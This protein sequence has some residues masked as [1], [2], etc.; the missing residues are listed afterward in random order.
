MNRFDNC[1]MRGIANEGGYKISL[2][3][4][5]SLLLG[6]L[7]LCASVT[8]GCTPGEEIGPAN[9][10]TE[11]V[12]SSNSDEENKVL[13]SSDEM[14]EEPEGVLE[15]EIAEEVTDPEAILRADIKVKGIYVT[16]PTA[17]SERLEELIELVKTTELNTMVIDIKSDEGIVTYKMDCDEAKDIGACVGYVK[18]M[19]ATIQRL[20][21]EG[22]YVI[23]RIACFKDPILAAGKPEYALCKADGTPVTDSKGIA[24]VNPYNEGVWNYVCTLAEKASEIGF[25]EIQFDYVRFPIGN[26]ANSADYGVD[27]NEYP[28]Q[29]CLTKFFEYVKLRLHGKGIIFGADLF[30]TVIG[31]DVDMKSTGQDYSSIC[32][33]SDSV[34]PMIYPS[35]YANGSF[36]VPV[37]D[38]NPYATVK[39]AM[40]KSAVVLSKN[41]DE[42]GNPLETG[43]IRPWLQCFTATWVPGHITYGG[44]ELQLQI[45][46][47]YDA[48]YDE[49]ILWNSA[50]RYD[51][52]QSGLASCDENE[53]NEN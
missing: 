52:V 43:V 47:V 20:H 51:A 41:V 22:I 26:D 31:N 1:K 32:T 18:D 3:K 11:T 42:S 6:V 7:L 23:G 29:E 37:P 49:W 16:G 13:G 10:E 45:Q 40:D 15:D 30:G 35:H 27:M 4:T 21:D 24:W 34:C 46:A 33:L 2:H 8:S 19:P 38:A 50:S 53:I 14:T 12:D 25:D 36:N 48:G 44:N 28:K 17:G 39:G 5:A 9:S